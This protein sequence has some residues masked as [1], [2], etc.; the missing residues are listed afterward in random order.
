MEIDVAQ[1]P[2]RAR[3]ARKA[4]KWTQQDVA[5]KAGVTLRTYQAFETG[6]ARPQPANLAAFVEVLGLDDHDDDQP[7]WSPDTQAFL[8]TL[9]IYM[10]GL[11]DRARARFIET[12]TRRIFQHARSTQ[13]EAELAEDAMRE[14]LDR[15]RQRTPEGETRSPIGQKVGNP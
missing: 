2:L 5:D 3:E 10:E 4:R 13:G 7:R 14:A 6:A 12:E 15:R 8:N 9:A 11:S 1:T